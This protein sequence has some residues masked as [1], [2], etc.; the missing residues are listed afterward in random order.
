V[1]ASQR[2]RPIASGPLA[3]L[4]LAVLPIVPDALAPPDAR[5][6]LRFAHATLAS[7]IS[8]MAAAVPNPFAIIALLL[9]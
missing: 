8:T 9:W 2:P 7:A 1:S 4:L 6:S 3:A 5:V